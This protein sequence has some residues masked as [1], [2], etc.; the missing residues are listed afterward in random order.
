MDYTLKTANELLAYFRW[1]LRVKNGVDGDPITDWL[2]AEDDIKSQANAIWEK[3]NCDP[4]PDGHQDR[5]WFDAETAILTGFGFTWPPQQPPSTSTSR[6][7]HISDLHFARSNARVGGS[8]PFFKTAFPAPYDKISEFLI[9]NA[10]Q[11]N[12]NVIV[13]TGDITDSG[14]VEDYRDVAKPFLDNLGKHFNIYHV[15]GNHDYCKFG[16]I[17]KGSNC[18]SINYKARWGYQTYI[19]SN[20]TYPNP[21]IVDCGGY[22]LILLDSMAAAIDPTSEDL[23]SQGKLGYEQLNTLTRMIGEHQTDRANGK[24]IVVCLHHHPFHINDI[25]FTSDSNYPAIV[26]DLNSG[27]DDAAAFLNIV[28]NQIDCLLFGHITPGVDTVSNPQDAIQHRYKDEK[29]ES[30]YRI[31]IINCENMEHAT[32]DNCFITVID[33]E[34]NQTEVYN[35]NSPTPVQILP[36]TT[37]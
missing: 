37:V 25:N 30:K 34:K 5:N 8:F 3:E 22:I 36:G 15:P 4:S 33:F 26:K 32:E 11:L 13:H 31:P 21:N 6:L 20:P 24:K 2:A 18:H 17:G 10:S 19:D 16:I 12:T 1:E 23:Y 35:I 7:I 28:N 27:L 29:L 9:N 14:N